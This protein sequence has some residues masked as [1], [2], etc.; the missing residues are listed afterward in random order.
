MYVHTTFD[1]LIIFNVFLLNHSIHNICLP[2]LNRFLSHLRISFSHAM[3]ILVIKGSP[4]T[5]ILLTGI[6]GCTVFVIVTGSVTS[7]GSKGAFIWLS[8]AGWQMMCHKFPSSL[9][10]Y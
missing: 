8:V 10:T 7:A 3:E 5:I 2:R 6:T 9:V 4:L 1:H